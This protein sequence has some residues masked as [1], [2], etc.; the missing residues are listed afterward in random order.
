MIILQFHHP[1]KNIIG[2]SNQDYRARKNS[3]EITRKSMR[4]FYDSSIT[5]SGRPFRTPQ[6][7]WSYVHAATQCQVV[8]NSTWRFNRHQSKLSSTEK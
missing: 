2:I 4:D 5:A 8:L 7:L 3:E 1:W 6:V